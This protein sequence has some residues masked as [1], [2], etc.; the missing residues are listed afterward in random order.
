V[1][2]NYRKF[3]CLNDNLD[4]TRE[5]D[6]SLV[7]AV[8]QDFYES[9]LPI[10]SSF[11]LPYVYRNRFLHVSE[12]RA[13]RRYRAVIHSATLVCI[14]LLAVLSLILICQGEVRFSVA[15]TVIFKIYEFH[16]FNHCRS[17]L[18]YRHYLFFFLIV[19]LNQNTAKQ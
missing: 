19:G 14:I 16:N 11:E 12:L 4:P 3:I 5:K 8:L 1:S 2:L 9:I 10:P 13:W 15:I 6:N 18:K 17:L 7:R